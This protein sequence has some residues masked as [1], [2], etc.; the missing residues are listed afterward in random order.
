MLI[1][2]VVEAPI[3]Q[4]REMARRGR[5]R[6]GGRASNR[7]RRCVRVFGADRGRGSRRSRSRALD[8]RTAAAGGETETRYEAVHATSQHTQ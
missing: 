2:R 1:A 3:G 6:P 8:G 4:A 7:A 5:G